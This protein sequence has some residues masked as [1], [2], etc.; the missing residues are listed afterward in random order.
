MLA[1]GKAQE[2]KA[3]AQGETNI[4]LML[5]E[6]LDQLQFSYTLRVNPRWRR[7]RNH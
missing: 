6:P 3:L 7:F 5:H 4:L 1:V 2:T